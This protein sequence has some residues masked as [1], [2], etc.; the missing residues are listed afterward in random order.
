MIIEHHLHFEGH[1]L[2]PT[3]PSLI[4][5]DLTFVLARAHRQMNAKLHDVLKARQLPVEQWRILSVLSDED[6][7]TVGSMCERVLMNFS[8]LSKTLDRMVSRALVHR[9]QDETDNRRVLV[10]ITEFGLELF[11]ACRADMAS[12]ENQLVGDLSEGETAELKNLL[13]RLSDR[14]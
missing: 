2:N 4:S 13:Q 11:Q 8:A 6:G 9:K 1:T 5:D 7:H 10:Y 14:T 12:N 3:A